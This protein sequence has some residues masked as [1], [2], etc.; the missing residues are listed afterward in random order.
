[1]KLKSVFVE[2]RDVVAYQI[3]DDLTAYRH[4]RTLGLGSMYGEQQLTGLNYTHIHTQCIIIIDNNMII[5]PYQF[6]ENLPQINYR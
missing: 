5:I 2:S 6:V 1:M 4:K 3:A